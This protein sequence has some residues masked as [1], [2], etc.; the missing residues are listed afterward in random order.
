MVLRMKKEEVSKSAR[1]IKKNDTKR[2]SNKLKEIYKFLEEG[3]SSEIISEE[4]FI[5]KRNNSINTFAHTIL[6]NDK[7]SRI[8]N[9][10]TSQKTTER[11]LFELINSCMEHLIRNGSREIELKTPSQLERFFKKMNFEKIGT[12]N[13]ETL[14]KY[15]VKYDKQS[16]LRKRFEDE[17]MLKKI[18]EKTSEQLLKLR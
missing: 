18:S 2:S 8:N 6:Y 17:E 1:F 7:K 16:S 13:K 3:H 15:S 9:I 5:K 11:D 10:I 14:M 12:K 4:N